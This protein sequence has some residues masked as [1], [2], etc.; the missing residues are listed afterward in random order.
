[1]RNE[2]KKSKKYYFYDNGIRNAL[3]NNFN[4]VQDRS[5]AGALWE[6]FCIVEMLKKAE[7]EQRFSNLYFWRTY[8]G[9][10]I[11][12]IEEKEGALYAYEFKWNP[13]RKVSLP[14]SFAEKYNVKGFKIITRKNVFG[15][16]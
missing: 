8:D 15:E 9:A 4:P 16:F 6:N 3:I 7:Y 5:D 12:L 14:K 1:M 2:I 10:E 11:D 13:K